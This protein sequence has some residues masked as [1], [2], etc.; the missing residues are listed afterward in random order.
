MKLMHR[1]LRHL[2]TGRAS[3]R[4]RFPPAS[5]AAITQ[6]IADSESAHRGELRFAIE[7]ALPPSRVLRG[8]GARARALEVSSELRVWDTE[9][10][11]GVLIYVLLA[12]RAIEIIADRG[13]HPRI[14]DNVW[15]RIARAM[16][17]EFAQ[18]RYEAGS[19]AG[20]AAVSRELI[21]LM[22]ATAA[23][24]NELGDDVTIL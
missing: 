1:L 14:A 22:P 18:G 21:R 10:N 9:E 24:P 19:L 7:A 16:Q 4:R 11:S 13:I 8:I 12:D 15:S 5:T 3:V 6:A 2:L 23:N 17:D 20:I